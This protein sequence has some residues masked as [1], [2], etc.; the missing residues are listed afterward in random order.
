MSTY[1]LIQ[2]VEAE[3]K[4]LGPLSLRQFIF[5]LIAVFCL[6]LSFILLT[7][8]LSFFLIITLPPALFFGFFAVPFGRDQPTEVWALA[9]I[10]FFLKPRKRVWNQSGVKELVTITAPKKIERVLTNGLSTYEVESRLK[11]LASTLDSRGWA[12][13]NVA[14]SSTGQAYVSGVVSGDTSDRL[15]D[16]STLPEVASDDTSDPAL[17]VM[18]DTNSP[19]SR[20]FDH[21]IDESSQAHRQ[22]IIQEMNA[23]AASMP[24]SS[25][26]APAPSGSSGN[27]W[28]MPKRDRGAPAAVMAADIPAQTAS[29]QDAALAASIKAHHDEQNI[30]YGNLRTLQPLGQKPSTVASPTNQPMPSTPTMQTPPSDPAIISLANNDDFTVATIAREAKKAKGDELADNEV[31]I[32]LH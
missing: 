6:Y 21:M 28:F 11:A 20:Q 31:V 22:Q 25:N 8:H 14:L 12:V 29:S 5:A 32:S 4:I 24:A 2:D 17:D 9:K 1:K 18:D 26:P 15:I 7:K 10:R 30:T 13:K 16:V 23:A 3:D 27:S 19:I